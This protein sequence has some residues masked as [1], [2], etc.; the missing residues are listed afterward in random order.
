MVKRVKHGR[1]FCILNSTWK[2][3]HIANNSKWK[4][5]QCEMDVY[6][7]V[8]DTYSN[9]AQ[10]RSFF[11]GAMLGQLKLWFLHI[12]KFENC[13]LCVIHFFYQ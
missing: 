10:I 13:L 4:K 9:S 6:H 5:T 2:H 11:C 1:E 3:E 12:L 7:S 8:N